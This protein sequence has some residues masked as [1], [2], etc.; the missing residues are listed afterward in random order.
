MKQEI[1]RSAQLNNNYKAPQEQLKAAKKKKVT[2]THSAINKICPFFVFFFLPNT[3]EH[4]YEHKL[5]ELTQP[6]QC[7]EGE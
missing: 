5:E 3:L 1:S 4:T 6:T 2:Y 7:Q